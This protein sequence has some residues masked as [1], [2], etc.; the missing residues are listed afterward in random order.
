[1][2]LYATFRDCQAAEEAAQEL[3]ERGAD[4]EDLHTACWEG[5]GA[6]SLEVPSGNL[7]RRHTRDI[8]FRHTPIMVGEDYGAHAWG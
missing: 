3:L 2:T 7:D 5:G 6:V 8:L 4:E 1:M